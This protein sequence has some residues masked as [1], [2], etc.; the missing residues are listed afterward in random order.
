[1]DSV[2][3]DWITSRQRELHERVVDQ[4]A[5]TLIEYLR[6]V[7]SG[8]TLLQQ[9]IAARSGEMDTL[10][11]LS[12]D[13]IDVLDHRVE[14]L[15]K[16]WVAA[17]GLR[18][19]ALEPISVRLEALARPYYE[20]SL[21]ERRESNAGFEIVYEPEIDIVS[22]ERVTEIRE[23]RHVRVRGIVDGIVELDSEVE[24]T[25]W[26]GFPRDCRAEG[27]HETDWMVLYHASHYLDIHV[28][29]F[30]GG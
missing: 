17:F 14:P 18:H 19:G 16:R 20:Y 3:R 7:L 13:L 15:A 5:E 9:M 30:R 26:M 6:A 12:Q 22:S 10:R 21:P 11:V 4:A 23:Q 25:L 24:I 8:N 28:R 27:D 29:P 1:M 2:K